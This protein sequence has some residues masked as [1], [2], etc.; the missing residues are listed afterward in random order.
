MKA[1]HLA[2]LLALSMSSASQAQ[3]VGLLGGGL[4]TGGMPSL[5][6]LSA[7][8]PIDGL[9][10]GVTPLALDGVGTTLPVL[11]QLLSNDLVGGLL[12]V[13]T[14]LTSTVAA[15]AVPVVIELVNTLTPQLGS[16]LGSGAFG[17]GLPLVPDLAG[18]LVPVVIT[19]VNTSSPVL[20]GVL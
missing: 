5:N 16:L 17:G 20:A 18:E 10:G 3:V 12:P 9:L 15:S 6:L 19:L 13:V 1:H 11:G 4:S 7:G 8:L 14:D 2:L